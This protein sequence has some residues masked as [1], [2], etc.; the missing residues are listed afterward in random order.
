MAFLQNNE[1]LFVAI[2]LFEII[3]H[4]RQDLENEQKKTSPGD[5]P[6]SVGCSGAALK[7]RS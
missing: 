2:I 6:N 5:V 1:T 7:P 4:W 3:D